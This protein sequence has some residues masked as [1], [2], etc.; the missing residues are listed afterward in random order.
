MTMNTLPLSNHV[1]KQTM[2]S[3]SA[4]ETADSINALIKLSESDQ[5]SLLEVIEDYFSF[6][7]SSNN[8]ENDSDSED[9][10]NDSERRKSIIVTLY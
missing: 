1:C 5:S 8:T 10:D 4:K 7:S 2:T 6:S 9:D 3:I